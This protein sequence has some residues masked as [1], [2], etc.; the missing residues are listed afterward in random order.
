MLPLALTQPGQYL[1]ETVNITGNLDTYL[2]Q[3]MH[4]L[5]ISISQAKD[6]GDKATVVALLDRF[7]ALADEYRARDDGDLTGTDR[8]ILATGQWIQDSV[9][10]IPSAVSALPQAIGSG[11]FR[12]V[13]PFALMYLGFVMLKRVR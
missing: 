7:K 8:F 10:A 6:R 3:Q 4:A 5:A 2:V 13:L 1:G 9:T 11:I 12:A